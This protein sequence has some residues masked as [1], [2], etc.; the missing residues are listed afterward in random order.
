MACRPP[1]ASQSGPPCSPAAPAGTGY[2][3]ILAR[4][5]G[6]SQPLGQ[7]TVRLAFLPAVAA[8]AF[9]PRAPFRPLT[10]TIPLHTPGHFP[11]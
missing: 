8:L 7:G 5:A 1:Q 2:L 11:R 4:L 3:A 6:A 9:V 10:H